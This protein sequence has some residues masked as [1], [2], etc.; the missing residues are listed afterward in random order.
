M[1]SRLF[2]ASSV[3]GLPIAYAAQENLEHA[4]EVTVWNQGI[5]ELSNYSV[6]SLIE[7][8]ECTDFGLFVFAPVDVTRMRGSEVRTVRD[9]VVFELGLSVGSLGR[10]RNFILIPRGKELEFHMPTDLL[11]ITPAVYDAERQDENM[12]AALG[13]A[14]N[15]I[16]RAM[17]KLGSL[18]SV[19]EPVEKPQPE[20]HPDRKYS[21]GDILAI[22][23]SW[24]GSRSVPD[25]CKVIHFDD[26]DRELKLPAGST[27]KFIAQVA[28]GWR[29]AVQQQGEHTILFKRIPQRPIVF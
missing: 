27:K 3:E 6:D 17:S 2:I 24:M 19:S 4:A 16:I 26:V 15:K 1:K 23:G 20:I 29:Y 25:N 18:K 13:P 10:E 28:H 12:Q 22:L 11:G 9:N 8:I 5:F 21:D 7:A 14:C